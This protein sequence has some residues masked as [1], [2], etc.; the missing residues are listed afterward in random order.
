MMVSNSVIRMPNINLCQRVNINLN[1]SRTLELW[2]L[3]EASTVHYALQL[4]KVRIFQSL[5]LKPTS[6]ILF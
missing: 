3:E 4:R 1:K 2:R 5:Y 6:K